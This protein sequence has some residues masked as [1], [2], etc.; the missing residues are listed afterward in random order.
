MTGGIY[1]AEK[2]RLINNRI[3]KHG[4]IV[5]DLYRGGVDE[6]TLGPDLIFTKKYFAGMYLKPAFAEAYWYSKN[7]YQQ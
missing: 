4:G 7:Q 1:N 2:I 5:L 3:I 6:S